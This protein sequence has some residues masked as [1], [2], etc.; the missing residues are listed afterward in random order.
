MEFFLK[1]QA[2][3]LVSVKIRGKEALHIYQNDS[4]LKKRVKLTFL[5]TDNV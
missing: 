4:T 3:P 2:C 1:S 5:S